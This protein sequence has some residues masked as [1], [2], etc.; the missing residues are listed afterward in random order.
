MGITISINYN[1]L[2][3]YATF[4]YVLNLALLLAVMFLGE[5]RLGAQRW[6]MIGP[7]VLQPSEF[8]KLFIIITFAN[9]ISKRQGKLNSFKDL[10]PAFLFIGI[11]MVLILKQ[12]DLGT[13]L[14]FMAIMFGMLFAGGA[15][16]GILVG[17]IVLGVVVVGSSL[18]LHFNYG[19]PI[20]LKEYQIKR[21]TIF[22]NPYE[23]PLAEG[24]HVIQSQIAIGSGGLY[25]RGL[26]AGSQN[27][28]NFLPE[29]HTDFIFSVVGE[30]LG[31]V[32]VAVLLSLF[33]ILLYRGLR[34]AANAKD[35]FGM[36]LAVGIV[37]MMCFHI[38]VNVGMTAGIMPV[39]GI[40]LPLVSYGGSSMLTN[41]TAIGI[42]LN[43]AIRRQ[44]LLF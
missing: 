30:E 26:Y 3:K 17:I 22:V 4:F 44:K 14:V 11:P 32:G 38:L 36:L 13:S 12:P 10:I 43:V 6:I 34:I 33:F 42:L 27:Q 15:R 19:M 8:A 20:P 25:G 35:N 23:S 5:S 18:Y 24:Y 1:S 40:P 39:T 16:P 29:Q 9:F 7:F 41:L 2:S 28:L 31:F 21:L 37:S